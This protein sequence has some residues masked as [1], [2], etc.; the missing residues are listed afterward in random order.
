MSAAGEFCV[1]LLRYKSV[2]LSLCFQHSAMVVFPVYKARVF[3]SLWCG[4]RES[5]SMFKPHS[6]NAAL[7]CRKVCG[8]QKS[9]HVHVDFLIQFVSVWKWDWLWYRYCY[10]V[11]L[12]HLA[13]GS[14]CCF[15]FCVIGGVA[16]I[17]YCMWYS[18]FNEEI[19]GI[20]TCRGQSRLRSIHPNREWVYWHMFVC[21]F[22][23]SLESLQIILCLRLAVRKAVMSGSCLRLCCTTLFIR[24]ANDNRR[25]LWTS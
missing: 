7:A 11:V 2:S 13:E 21:S 6:L 15:L 12:F 5:P 16:C 20:D 18:T 24:T 25:R 9:I 10:N 17:S 19:S 8:L 4:R 23:Y 1:N 14:W 3:V 22:L